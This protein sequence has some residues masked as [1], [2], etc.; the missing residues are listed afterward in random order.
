M[1]RGPAAMLGEAILS[2]CAL[3]SHVDFVCALSPFDVELEHWI[4]ARRVDWL[5]RMVVAAPLDWRPDG[6]RLGFVGTLDHAPNLEGLVE[7]L[8]LLASADRRGVV[9]IVSSSAAAGRWLAERHPGVEYLGALGDDD[10]R[11]EAA[12]WNAFIHPIFCYPRGCS[13]KLATAIGWHL[14]IVTT[15]MGYR[16]YELGSGRLVV[17]DDPS[18]FVAE[19][20]R[21]LDNAAAA[22]ARREVAKVAQSAPSLH[23]NARRLQALLSQ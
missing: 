6:A 16:G 23:D 3:R 21:L 11:S 2:E 5:P 22:E 17:A 7:V 1:R 12:T 13:T 19:C 4:G 18:G 20:L 9:R 14:P 10:L 15:T 8:P